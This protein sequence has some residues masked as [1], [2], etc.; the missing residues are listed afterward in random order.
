MGCGS[1]KEL[2]KIFAREFVRAAV[3]LAKRRQIAL[4]ALLRD[5]QGPQALNRGDSDMPHHTIEAA[6]FERSCFFV[7]AAAAEKNPPRS[8]AKELR[9]AE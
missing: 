1:I 7:G 8:T 6:Q 9:I 3:D 2:L 5:E 4:L